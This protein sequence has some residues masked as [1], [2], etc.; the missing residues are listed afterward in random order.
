M[1]ILFIGDIV[2]SAG[3]DIVKEILPSLKK[4]EN[5]DL[6]IA[7]ADNLASGRG[8]TKSVVEEVLSY[9]VDYFTGGD[10]IFGQKGT[11]DI[12]DSLPV[13]RA[14]N[15]PKGTP[16]KGYTVIDTGRNGKVLLI[17]LTGRTCFGGPSIYLDDP[18][19][20][21]DPVLQEFKD[22]NLS[23]TIIDFHGEAT[24]EKNAFAFYLDGKVTA[25]I[26]T[27]THIPTCD[28]RTLPLGT[29]FITDVGMTGAIDSV[30]GVKTDIV[31]K[32]FRTAQNQKFEWESTGTKA[33]RSVLLDTDTNHISR[34]DKII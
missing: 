11:Q 10:H 19:S 8:I 12:I 31:I 23:A 32:L 17:S 33:F 9:G 15:Y 29:M 4:E 5:I 24:S 28:E 26:G 25:V 30:L 14:A 3:R 6:V 13:L 1:R 7:S 2:A 34:L 18:F 21:I 27:H 16:G 20:T 22:E